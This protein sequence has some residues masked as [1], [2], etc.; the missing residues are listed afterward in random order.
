[1][2]AIASFNYN[3][4]C[5]TF[6][7]LAYISQPLCQMYW[8]L[9]TSYVRNDGSRHYPVKDPNQQAVLLNL[10]TAH[11]IVLFAPAADGTTPSPTLVGHVTNAAEGSVNA[12]VEWGATVSDQEAF[13][14][15]TRYGAAYWAA[16]RAYRTATYVPPSRKR[17]MEPWRVFGAGE[18]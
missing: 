18:W 2:G 1:M 8:T 3:L 10:V 13:F 12:T 4:F 14:L 15:Q 6:P 7:E 9:A 5:V 17:L 11:L 16:S